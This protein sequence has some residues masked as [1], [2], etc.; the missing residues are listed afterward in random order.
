MTTQQ[1]I[2]FRFQRNVCFLANNRYCL[3]KAANHCGSLN[4]YCEITGAIPRYALILTG[5]EKITTVNLPQYQLVIGGADDSD[6][7]SN[8]TSLIDIWKDKVIIETHS[9]M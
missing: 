8:P 5:G 7:Q 9:F 6:I 2:T 3:P 1:L 4:G